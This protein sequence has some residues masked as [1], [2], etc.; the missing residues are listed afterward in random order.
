MIYL[1]STRIHDMFAH[2]HEQ[3]QE[4]YNTRSINTKM[5]KYFEKTFDKISEANE[6]GARNGTQ[7]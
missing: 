2:A 1:I 7:K 5:V 3:K 6:D 4:R